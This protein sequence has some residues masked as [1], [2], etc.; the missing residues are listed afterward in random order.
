MK[1]ECENILKVC[2]GGARKNF[3][4]TGAPPNDSIV[5]QFW[6]PRLAMRR[7]YLYPTPTEK[8]ATRKELYLCFPA[9]SA[10]VFSVFQVAAAN[11]W[12]G[13]HVGPVGAPDH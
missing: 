3:G 11:R 1:I 5:A 7:D 4:R 8:H 10:R 6:P 2:L 9:F 13:A 12:Q